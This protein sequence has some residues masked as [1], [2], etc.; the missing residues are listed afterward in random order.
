MC[1][2]PL[3]PRDRLR[4]YGPHRRGAAG[5]EA[6]G[7]VCARHRGDDRRVGGDAFGTGPLADVR[8]QVDDG[9]RAQL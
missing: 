9:R 8:V 4:A 2:D 6:A 5:V 3:V 7:D 1:P